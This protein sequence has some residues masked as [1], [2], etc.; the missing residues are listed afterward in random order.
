MRGGGDGAALGGR[1]GGRAEGRCSWAREDVTTTAAVVVASGASSGANSWRAIG[2]FFRCV[3]GVRDPANWLGVALATS[4][5]W[6]LASS[7]SSSSTGT[8]TEPQS[9][10]NQDTEG[11]AGWGDGWME[12]QADR[13]T[14]L[15]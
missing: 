8:E 4:L 14:D 2:G 1:G 13:R 11:Q 15:E 3:A 10:Q 12:R 9:Q 5:R 6:M 7:S